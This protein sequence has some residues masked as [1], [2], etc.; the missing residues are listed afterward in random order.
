M[1]AV[2]PVVTVAVL[3]LVVCAG[4]FG[5]EVMRKRCPHCGKWLRQPQ[6]FCPGCGAELG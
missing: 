3:A 5:W 1:G 6:R 2:D 4:I